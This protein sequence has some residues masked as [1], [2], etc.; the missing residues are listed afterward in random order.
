MPHCAREAYLLKWGGVGAA[1]LLPPR[2]PPCSPRPDPKAAVCLMGGSA[3]TGRA[4]LPRHQGFAPNMQACGRRGSAAACRWR[5]ARPRKPLLRFMIGTLYLMVMMHCCAPL[6]CIF[7]GGASSKRT[8][9]SELGMA[10]RACVCAGTTY[11]C[12]EG[13]V[14]EEKGGNAVWAGAARGEWVCCCGAALA[15]LPCMHSSCVA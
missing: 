5:L 14:G 7:W 13:A 12:V 3:A 4:F 2:P 10:A 15:A 9:N 8:T 11:A 1:G 6:C